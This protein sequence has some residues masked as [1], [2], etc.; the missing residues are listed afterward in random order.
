MSRSDNVGTNGV[1][2]LARHGN[3]PWDR[4]P[5]ARKEGMTAMRTRPLYDIVALLART[6]VGAVFIAHG[7]QKIQVGIDQTSEQFTTMDVPFPTAAAV[8]STFVELLGGAALILG[9]GLPV[10]GVLLFLDMAGAFAFVNGPNGLFL[11]NE[12]GVAQNGF[13]LVLVLGLASLAFAVGG[14][15]RLTLDSRLFPRRREDDDE[16]S[17]PDWVTSLHEDREDRDADP[18]TASREQP[19]AVKA[20]AEPAPAEKAAETKK[21]AK[22]PAMPA[23]TG[24]PTVAEVAVSPRLAADIVKDTSG[25][26]L[27]AGRKRRRSGGKGSGQKS[28]NTSDD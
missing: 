15:G 8:Y 7:W 26:T 27:V 9:L 20:P 2:S 22:K 19:R 1:D 24:G 13:E 11:V 23:T 5:S 28:K 25:D 4:A 16:D 3:H 14:A 17:T 6:G 10:A 21:P 18:P 12:Q